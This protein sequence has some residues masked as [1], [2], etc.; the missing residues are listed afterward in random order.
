MENQTLI[1]FIQ[2]RTNEGATREQIDKD[3]SNDGRF[4]F[5]NGAWTEKESA[6]TIKE[7][8]GASGEDFL[9]NGIARGQNDILEKIGKIKRNFFIIISLIPLTIFIFS[10]KNTFNFLENSVKTRGV[11]VELSTTDFSDGSPA[12]CPI[13]EYHDNNSNL[14]KFKSDSCLGGNSFKN[15]VGDEVDVYYSSNSDDKRWGTFWGIWSFSI[16][17]AIFF[18]TAIFFAFAPITRMKVRIR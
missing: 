3:L 16:V 1:D 18:V 9:T 10:T 2:K 17:S 14:I 11:I 8:T 5:V 15:K 13:I 4:V 12:Y 6:K 7:Q